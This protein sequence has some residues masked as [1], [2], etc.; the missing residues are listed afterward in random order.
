[1]KQYSVHIPCKFN[2]NT[3][4]PIETLASINQAALTVFGG[5]TLDAVPRIGAWYDKDNDKVYTEP[6]RVMLIGADRA[7]QVESF[8]AHVC[9]LLKQECVYMAGPDGTVT[10]IKGIPDVVEIEHE[11]AGA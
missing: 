9:R 10:F 5:Y 11:Q 4:I 1:M 2:D 3:E 8:A 6:M 7:K